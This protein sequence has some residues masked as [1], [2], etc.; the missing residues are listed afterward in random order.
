MN[1]L[2]TT[3]N[4]LYFEKALQE[5]VKR[6]R[7]TQDTIAQIIA[8]GPHGILQISEAFGNPFKQS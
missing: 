5:G 4:R 7:I 2:R 6:K 1:S 8:S 3:D